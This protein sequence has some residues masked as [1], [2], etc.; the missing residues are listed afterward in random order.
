MSNI[1]LNLSPELMGNLRLLLTA[2][3]KSPHTGEEAIMAAAQ[4]LMMIQ[5]ATA[6][7]Q[8]PKSNGAD[9]PQAEAAA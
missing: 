7:A 2:G 6:E 9:H 4:L 8:K 5:E 3:A 1:T